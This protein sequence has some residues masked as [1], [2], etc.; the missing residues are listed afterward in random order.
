MMTR[1]RRQTEMPDT[2]LC[3]FFLC[4][5]PECGKPLRLPL[6]TLL[7]LTANPADPSIR[8]SAIAVLCH[9]CTRINSYSLL[10][11]S[12]DRV[13]ADQFVSPDRSAG[14]NLLKW[15]RCDEETCK[16]R[17]PLIETW[18]QVTT[19]VRQ[20][21]L[22]EEN[23]KKVNWDELSTLTCPEVHQIPFPQP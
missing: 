3:R 8:A 20:M 18:S 17:L 15:L 16:S 2:I 14:I 19:H 21:E 5:N 10:Q 22:L 1:F 4:R 12:S 23:M 9:H 13:D 7:W 11:N 6:E